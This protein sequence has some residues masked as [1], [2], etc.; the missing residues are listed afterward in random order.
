MKKFWG[1]SII[2]LI[3]L[4]FH[5]NIV[6]GD[7]WTKNKNISNS[8]GGSLRPDIAADGK[9]IYVVWEEEWE[10]LYFRRS[11]DGG[12]NW[13]AAKRLTERGVEPTIAVNGSNI[14]VVWSDKGSSG[15]SYG[16]YFMQST[17]G[18]VN[19]SS[20]KRLMHKKGD[21]EYPA[22]AA[23]GSNI[24]VVWDYRKDYQ[25][26]LESGI[27]FKRSTNRGASW[28]SNKPITYKKLG[29]PAIAVSGSNIY[30]VWSQ[31][32]VYFK[33]EIYFKQSVDSGRTWKTDL[34]L[35]D[36]YS[37]SRNPDIAVDG[38][39]I[40]VVWGEGGIFFKRSNNSGVTWSTEKLL[41]DDSGGD[42]NPSIAVFGSNIYVVW[43]KLLDICFIRSVD[44]GS[45]W[46]SPFCLT[47]TDNAAFP[48][49]AADG[50]N[51][52]V[53]WQ[54]YYMSGNYEVLFKKGI[55]DKR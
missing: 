14:Y 8:L 49:M 20:R 18:G 29:F 21:S 7:T 17:D 16:T 55:M 27:Y 54:G 19:W 22:I 43:Q 25:D 48:A 44:K 37:Y 32:D 24:Y 4:M 13:K 12:V 47:K 33:S 38:S 6:Y 3:V 10:G 51:V 30:I 31:Y 45:T 9:N 53:V 42:D 26:D 40:Y 5:L 11:V 36:S 35:T 2:V 41:T 23:N 1:I 52:F 39:N 15:I 50:Y 46:K 34:R 28:T